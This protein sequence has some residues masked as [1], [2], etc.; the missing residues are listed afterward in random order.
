M[1]PVVVS[2]PWRPRKIRIASRA[3]CAMLAAGSMDAPTDPRTP[4]PAPPPHAR[5]AELG[6]G[7]PTPSRRSP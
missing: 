6:A 1:A 5:G 4:A 2:G 3:G 7:P